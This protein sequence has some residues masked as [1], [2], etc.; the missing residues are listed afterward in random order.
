MQEYLV[1]TFKFGHVSVSVWAYFVNGNEGPVYIF[2][3]G[4]KN[5]DS[6][7]KVLEISL[8]PFLQTN[9]GSFM[10]NDVYYQE[11]NAPIY[12]SWA[13]RKSISDNEALLLDKPTKSPDPN[14]IEN[15]WFL[16]KERYLKGN[17]LQ[18]N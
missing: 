14:P 7:I 6:Y 17:F 10:G 9:A 1:P 15:L 5:S 12:T 18:Q 4:T 16:D 2:D 3:D 8:P 13:A 11:N